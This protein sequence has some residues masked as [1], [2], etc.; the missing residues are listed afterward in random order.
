MSYSIL[1]VNLEE[2]KGD[3]INFWKRNFPTWPEKKFTW[4]YKNN[5]Y[6]RAACWIIKESKAD[7]VAGSTAIFPRK[8]FVKGECLLGGITG[9]FG[10]DTKYRILG[11]ALQLQ[12]AGISECN[13]NQFDFLYGYPNEKSEP[14]QR[15]AGFKVIGSTYRMV[16][17][18]RSNHYLKRHINLP[19]VA[20]L[21]SIAAD[22]ILKVLSKESYYKKRGGFRFEVLSIFDKRFDDLW[23][24]ASSHY[25]IIGERSSKFLNWRFT[26]CPY[27]KYSIF[28]MIKKGSNEI[29]GYIVYYVV[30]HNVNIADL[31][32]A[33]MNKYIDTLLSEFLL[34]QRANSVDTISIISFTNGGLM[35]KL[36]E[37]GFSIRDDVRNIVVHVPNNT[38]FS[39]YLLDRNNWYLTEGDN[40]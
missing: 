27:K 11:P 2:S 22:L 3:I 13:E 34:F 39:S 32:V 1:K 28:A 29:I 40:D 24:K 35:D 10:V 4:F 15:R 23:Q 14:V 21:V 38:P 37:Y 19:I 8:V 16:K 26:Q 30:R 18:L 36:K 20:K 6:G 33:D 9:D 7:V 25:S 31:L 12:K 17:I 5:P